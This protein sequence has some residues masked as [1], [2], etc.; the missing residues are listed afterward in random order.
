[1]KPWSR[2]AH[3]CQ[4][5]S[6]FLKH[7]AVRSISKPS[8]WNHLL[9]VR[10]P[11]HFAVTHVYSWVERGTV[12][13]A[14]TGTARSRDE[15]TNHEATAPPTHTYTITGSL[16]ENKYFW[17]FLAYSVEYRVVIIGLFSIRSPRPRLLSPLFI[18]KVR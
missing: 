9:F 4:I 3:N 1:M 15:R 11:Q 10:L 17:V 6:R 7:E 2:P 16:S 18:N 12:K 13:W 5:I 8:A 14:R